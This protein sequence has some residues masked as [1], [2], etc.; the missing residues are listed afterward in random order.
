MPQKHRLMERDFKHLDGRMIYTES[1]QYLTYFRSKDWT[2]EIPAPRPV[3]TKQD[4][5]IRYGAGEFGN[6]SPTWDN[7]DAM[8]AEGVLEWSQYRNAKY[9][10]RN[11]VA[12]GPTWYNVLAE[13][14]AD[15]WWTATRMVQERSL[16][17]SEMCPT[18]R[19]LINAEVM[20][21]V[22]GLY[23]YYSTVRKP[24]RDSLKEGGREAKGVAAIAILRE[25]LNN[26]S[27]EWL[28]HL[29]DSYPD[30]VVELTALDC[31]WGTEPGHNTL[32][33]E[34]RGGY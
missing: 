33:W 16:Y 28:Q 24:M 19:T 18:E 27:Y 32:F 31:C 11:R 10:I 1:N 20:R 7:L 8:A 15:A 23:L 21:D 14:L 9:H 25:F 3:L 2:D 30:H 22:G 6:R 5:V 13:T 12:G 34:V 4:F 17:I 26:N 29:L